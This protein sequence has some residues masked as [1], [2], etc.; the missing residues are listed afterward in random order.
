[1]WDRW[2]KGLFPVPPAYD[3]IVFFDNGRGIPED[4]LPNVFDPFFQSKQ[5]YQT[6]RGKAGLGLL[7][8]KKIVE[9]HGATLSI[10]SPASKRTIVSVTLPRMICHS[11]A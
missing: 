2:D 9:A 10:Q 8:A 11:E 3:Q 4:D 5:E 1:M 6:K 7:I